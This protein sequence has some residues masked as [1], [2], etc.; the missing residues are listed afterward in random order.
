MGEEFTEAPKPV[1]PQQAETQVPVT[2]VE[3]KGDAWDMAHDEEYAREGKTELLE[4]PKKGVL[5]LGSH[6]SDA[7][8]KLYEAYLNGQHVSI[9][10]NGEPM[11]SREIGELGINR[12]YEKYTGYDKESYKEHS[13][14]R[15][16]A[17]HAKYELESFE[18]KYAAK[19]E[20]PKLVEE[21]ASLIQPDSRGEW[22][23]CL[24]GRASDIYHGNDSKSAIALMTAHS[25]GASVEDLKKMFD[26]EGHSGASGS[27]TLRMIKHFYID[28]D[29]L[30]EALTSSEPR[31]T[32]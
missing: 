8:D 28:G 32:A 4:E 24:E 17:F 6:K 1:E 22:R 27:M 21:S 16:A 25:T 31:P 20:V 5:M 29:S 13:R 23:E 19:R 30:V 15:D 3:D 9:D 12:A 18:G 11:N 2:Y 10:F 14:L 7:V 26:D